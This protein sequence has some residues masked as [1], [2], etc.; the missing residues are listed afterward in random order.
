MP[1]GQSNQGFQCGFSHVTSGR[2]NCH[3]FHSVSYSM[4]LRA[5]VI[6]YT[7]RTN[8]RISSNRVLFFFPMM[9]IA[10]LGVF[11]HGYINNTC[12]IAKKKKKKKLNDTEVYWGKKLGWLATQTLLLLLSRFSPVRLCATPEKAAHQAP[13]SLGFSRREH[14][15]GLRCSLAC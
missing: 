15:S 13:P 10:L 11:S 8:H 1:L 3:H 14:W 12:F 6:K 9:K 7:N 4:F 5:W 2:R